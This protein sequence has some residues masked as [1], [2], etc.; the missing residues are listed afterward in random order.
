MEKR[1]RLPP[2]TYKAII[3]WVKKNKGYTIHHT[4]WIAD[5]KEQMGYQM[6]KSP[7]RKGSDR[8][9]PCP[10]ANINDIREALEKA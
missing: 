10:K 6:K 2:P 1:L 9:V 5:V 8:V 7:N 4:C 3:D